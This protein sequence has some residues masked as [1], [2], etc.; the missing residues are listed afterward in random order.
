MTIESSEFFSEWL[1]LFDPYVPGDKWPHRL[2]AC[3][4]P[5]SIPVANSCEIK[6]TIF[7]ASDENNEPILARAS[8]PIPPF[9]MSFMKRAKIISQILDILFS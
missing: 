5:S 2:K 9:L 1:E 3:A 8:C 4:V 7:R 6:M